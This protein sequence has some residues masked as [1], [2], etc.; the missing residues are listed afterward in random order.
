MPRFRESVLLEQHAVR[1]PRESD[2]SV[3][4]ESVGGGLGRKA[5]AQTSRG[6]FGLYC[7]S[8]ARFVPFMIVLEPSCR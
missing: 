3:H 1:C 4:N 6:M 5:L 7:G 8:D 2:W